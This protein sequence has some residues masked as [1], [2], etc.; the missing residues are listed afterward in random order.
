MRNIE[1]KARLADYA[2]AK[3]AA[4]TVATR[5]LGAQHQIDTYFH[6]RHGRLKLRQIDRLRAELVWYARADEH[7]PKPSD[8]QLVPLQH[9]E[10]LKAALAAALGVRAVVEKHREIF[11]YHNVRI[12]LDEVVGLGQF[13]EFEAV[14]GGDADEAAGRAMLDTLMQ[15]FAI[16]PADL[17]A[18]SYGE[19]V[20]EQVPGRSPP[21]EV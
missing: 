6:C 21:Q 9:P 4:E 17:L 20:P 12:H 19:M 11:L 3:K 16:L 7:G 15:H 5:R 13:I 2:A 10:T 14:L 18:Q 8:Y 1:L